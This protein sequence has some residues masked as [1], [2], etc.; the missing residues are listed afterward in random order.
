[1]PIA[2]LNSPSSRTIFRF[3]NGSKFY[4]RPGV[5]NADNNGDTHGATNEHYIVEIA[6]YAAK[7]PSRFTPPINLIKYIVL[8]V[9]GGM[10]GM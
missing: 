2:K 10:A 1:M 9:G 5:R 6:T 8:N 3:T 4:P 7:A